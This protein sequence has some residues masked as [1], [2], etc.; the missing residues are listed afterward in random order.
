[1]LHCAHAANNCTVDLSSALD[2]NPLAATYLANAETPSQLW[3][4]HHRSIDRRIV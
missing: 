4:R 1:L 2:F 3:C